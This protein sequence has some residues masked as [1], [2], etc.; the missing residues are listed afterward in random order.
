MA[1]I[2]WLN[3]NAEKWD[4]EIM[5]LNTEKIFVSKWP[6]SGNIAFDAINLSHYLW[7]FAYSAFNVNSFSWTFYFIF[8]FELKRHCRHRCYCCGFCCCCLVD[9]FGHFICLLFRLLYV[10]IT[11][12]AYFIFNFVFIHSFIGITVL[13]QP[14]IA[15][16]WTSSSRRNLTAQIEFYQ[17]N[18]FNFFFFGS[19]YFSLLLFFAILF[20][21]VFNAIIINRQHNKIKNELRKRWINFRSIGKY[22]IEHIQW[23]KRFFFVW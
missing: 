16:N 22:K 9:G 8:S 19:F 5:N 12:A 13:H 18:E 21:G 11:F 17:L 14:K 20:V 15:V 6:S 10:V 4:R 1:Y 3:R 2:F 23:K 7:L